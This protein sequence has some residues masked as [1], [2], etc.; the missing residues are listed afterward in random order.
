M[1]IKTVI[2]FGYWL[3]SLAVGWAQV[4]NVQITFKV[5][6][7][8]GKPVPGAKVGIYFIHAKSPLGVFAVND[9][10]KSHI[11]A[12]TDINGLATIGT[13]SVFDPSVTYTVPPL[14]GYYYT[15]GG[16]YLFKKVE[17]GRWQPWNPTLEL[18]QCN[19]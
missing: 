13:S 1:K 16:Q 8:F 14:A 10:E 18:V 2:L 4:G 12:M 6:D 3:A 17:N 5:M 11:D 15:S 7:D 9:A 19:S